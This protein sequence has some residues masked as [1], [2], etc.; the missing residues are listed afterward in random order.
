MTKL[1]E[2]IVE[3]SSRLQFMHEQRFAGS[4][5]YF[6]LSLRWLLCC[7]K[8]KKFTPLPKQ[9]NLSYPKSTYN[10]S[11]A[12]DHP[13]MSTSRRHPTTARSQNLQH[14]RGPESINS[15]ALPAPT[16]EKL[17]GTRA[18][19][20]LTT[21]AGVYKRSA[22]MDWSFQEGSKWRGIQT[23]NSKRKLPFSVKAISEFKNIYKLVF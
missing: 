12:N 8:K 15:G 5:V 14:V 22:C 19:R 17:T 9:I 11:R 4:F 6:R 13:G 20:G 10:P 7:K 23:K 2:L 21:N 16:S 18:C 3:N 1:L